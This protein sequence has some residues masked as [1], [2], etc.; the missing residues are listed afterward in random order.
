MFLPLDERFTT[1]NAWLNL[2]RV[3]PHTVVTPPEDLI[4]HMKQPANVSVLQAWMVDNIAGCDALVISSELYLYGGLIASR[5]SNDTQDD[6][7]DRV[8]WL[9]QLRLKNRDTLKAVYLSSVVMRI[10][11]YNEDVEE[12]WYWALY[13]ADLYQ[14]SFYYGR[15]VELHNA[16]DL[17]MAQQY[18]AMVPDHVVAEFL[19]RRS[20]NFN[21]TSHLLDLQKKSN[22]TLFQNMFITLDDNSPFGFNILESKALQNQTAALGL[23]NTVYI[24][25]G[26]DEVGLTMLARMCVDA[27]LDG[28]PV[29]MAVVY[30]DPVGKEYIPACEG[31]PM[32]MTV[33]QQIAAAGGVFDDDDDDEDDAAAAAAAAAAAG[34]LGGTGADSGAGQ[35][36][37]EQR[38]RGSSSSSSSSSSIS[39]GDSGVSGNN[40]SRR[41]R[42]S[43]IR[44]ATDTDKVWLLVNNFSTKDQIGADSQPVPGNASDF[45]PFVGLMAQAIANRNI[46]VGFADNR[47]LNG[48]DIAFCSWLE[49]YYE[50]LNITSFAYAGWNTDGNTLGTVISNAI[51]LHLYARTPEGTVES[52]Q[53]AQFNLLRLVEDLHYQVRVYVCMCDVCD[54]CDV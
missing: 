31:Q 48:A 35:W 43:I 49:Q 44:N 20:R 30:R 4:S 1:R 46:V 42:S 17:A 26:A 2:A 18:E 34:L 29:P 27:E 45:D 50:T 41:S 22:N 13:G 6:I 33:H 8:D 7:M 47:Y 28:V 40:S 24:Y 36:S 15:Y 21:V 37:K 12:P 32:D 11:S 14:F 54:V 16:S 5:E 51:L 53:N 23:N 25:P 3:T 9:V 19:W 38:R 39:R 52:I 10:P